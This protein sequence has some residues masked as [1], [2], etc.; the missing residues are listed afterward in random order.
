MS[1]CLQ[2]DIGIGSN[3]LSFGSS[4]VKGNFRTG[5]NAKAKAFEP[6]KGGVFDYGFGEVHVI[7]C[8]QPSS[9]V[10]IALLYSFIFSIQNEKSSHKG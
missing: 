8:P 3:C 7:F 1:F 4:P 6:G 10:I 5:L 9:F 2:Y